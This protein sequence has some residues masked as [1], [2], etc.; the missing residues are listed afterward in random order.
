MGEKNNENSSSNNL[1][2]G[3]M[4]IS[5][6]VRYDKSLRPRLGSDPA[7]IPYEAHH[8][9]GESDSVSTVVG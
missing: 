9:D 6:W 7:A 2:R 8:V 5:C 1:Y 3:V 4:S